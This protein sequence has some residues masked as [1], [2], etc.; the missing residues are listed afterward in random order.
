MRLLKRDLIGCIAALGGRRGNDM[1]SLRPGLHRRL[2]WKLLVIC[3]LT[4]SIPLGTN[5]PTLSEERDAV[6]ADFTKLELAGS[7]HR[8]QRT[9]SQSAEQ[10]DVGTLMP[11]L[12]AWITAKTGLVAPEAPR[13]A[14]VP[15]YRMRPLFDA[16]AYPDRQPQADV[17]ADQG[18]SDA[19][20]AF[21]VRA[22][23]T[24]YLPETW[25]P[26]ALRDQSKLLHELVHHVQRFNRVVPACP[27]ALERQAYELQAAWLRERGVAEPYELMGT[28]QFTV[29]V[30]S[31]CI[32]DE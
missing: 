8:G 3:A 29:L 23:A 21:Y 31:A 26:S 17:P 28:D 22:T 32:P 1:S 14:F 6:R 19:P 30:L 13:I 5:S 11:T 18:A 7:G 24:V 25:R 12:L 15:K 20:L 9:K 10:D 4:L 2:T 16:A 27:G